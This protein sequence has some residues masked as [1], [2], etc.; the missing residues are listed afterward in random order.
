MHDIDES[1]KICDCGVTIDRIGE[2]ISAKLDIIPAVFRGIR[3]MCPKYT[4]KQC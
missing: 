2:G 4:C 1:E 3:H